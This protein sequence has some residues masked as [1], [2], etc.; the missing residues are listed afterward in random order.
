MDD[1][2]KLQIKYNKQLFEGTKDQLET[3]RNWSGGVILEKGKY[4]GWDFFA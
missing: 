1:N 2:H 3:G 4:T